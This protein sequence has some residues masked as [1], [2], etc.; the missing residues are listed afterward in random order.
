[1]SM[2]MTPKDKRERGV[3]H[4]PE[5][6]V[7]T[8]H[9]FDVIELALGHLGDIQ[10]LVEDRGFAFPLGSRA[11][12]EHTRSCIKVVLCD[13]LLDSF[14][15]VLRGFSR[16]LGGQSLGGRLGDNNLGNGNLG[17]S[18]AT[19]VVASCL[20]LV[21]VNELVSLVGATLAN[22]IDGDAMSFEPLDMSLS[23]RVRKT[24][25]L[26]EVVALDNLAGTESG[27]SLMK[28]GLLSHNIEPHRL[29]KRI[30]I[31]GTI[32]LQSNWKVKWN[33]R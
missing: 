9:R 12:I 3:L 8:E 33:F 24:N 1:M 21:D 2:L 23:R 10:I 11:I 22:Y 20:E 7:D 17:A 26:G 15:H 6:E 19:T 28:T 31:T 25:L 18:E 4:S 30:N 14:G 16:L 29:E 5:S 32:V 13:L 27:E